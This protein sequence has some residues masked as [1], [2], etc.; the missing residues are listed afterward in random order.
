[1]GN[2]LPPLYQYNPLFRH[3]YGQWGK[4]RRLALVFQVA[5][6]LDAPVSSPSNRIEREGGQKEEEGSLCF[7]GASQCSVDY[8]GWDGDMGVVV[9]AILAVL[10]A[11]GCFDGGHKI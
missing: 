7:Q 3:V 8:S 11:A 1:M 10:P 4:H 6:S 5:N 2:L 9:I